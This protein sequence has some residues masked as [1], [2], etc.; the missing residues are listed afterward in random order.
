MLCIFILWPVHCELIFGHFKDVNLEN[1]L[2]GLT[3]GVNIQFEILF[4]E[5]WGYNLFGSKNG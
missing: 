3:L 2:I 5:K 1:N 4:Y